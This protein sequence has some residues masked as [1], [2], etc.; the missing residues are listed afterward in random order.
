MIGRGVKFQYDGW[1]KPTPGIVTGQVGD[2]SFF[3][4]KFVD[5][6]SDQF[7][8]I[9]IN[10]ML[11][12]DTTVYPDAEA[13]LRQCRQNLRETA[14]QEEASRYQ[15]DASN[16]LHQRRNRMPMQL[17]SP[18]SPIRPKD[19]VFRFPA[20]EEPRKLQET[21]GKGKRPRAPADRNGKGAKAPKKEV[22]KFRMF[23]NHNVTGKPGPVVR[24]GDF[25][26]VKRRGVSDRV[27][28]VKVG[29]APRR[30]V[31]LPFDRHLRANPT[32]W[33]CLFASPDLLCG[34]PRSFLC[35]F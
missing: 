22:S 27:G 17:Y 26:Y 35:P 12:G 32:P 5:G 31:A 14:V 15:I 24:L 23:I 19:H 11:D 7:S 20:A 6:Y 8:Y 3:N 33:W 10:G 25:V 34:S 13:W 21:Q 2:S 18:S 30:N 16:V 28:L 29:R 1:E 9:E 4:V